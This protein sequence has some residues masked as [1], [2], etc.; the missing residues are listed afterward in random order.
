[1]LTYARHV[2]AGRVHPSRFVS[3]KLIDV[4]PPTP[5]PADILKGLAQAKD[6]RQALDG[7]SPP[8][9][10]YKALRAKLAEARA[11]TSD[12]GPAPIEAGALLR[13]G[14][15]DERVP[16]LRE[17][18]GVTDDPASTAYDAK[19]AEAVKAFQRRSG[20]NPDGVVG[21]ATV[22]A[23][24]GPRKDRDLAAI[25]SNMERWRWLP[26]ELGKL[27][28]IVNIPDFTAQIVRDGKTVHQTRIVVGKPS[29]ATPVFSDSIENI[30]VNPTWHVPE[31]IIYGEY[32]PALQQDPTVLARMGLVMEHNRDGSISIRQ[33]PGEANALGRLKFN[34]PNRHQVYMHD[35]PDKKLFT[36]D[37]R[38][39]SHGCMRVQNPHEFAEVLLGYA[40]P[41]EGLS[42]ERLTRMYGK[43]EQTLKFRNPVSVH[44]TYQTA[45]V[46]GSGKLVVRE[47]LYGHDGKVQM[48]LRSMDRR[49]AD[50]AVPQRLETS[51]VSRREAARQFRPQGSFGLSFFERLF[52][53]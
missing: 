25:I 9:P 4:N 50:I 26:R 44:I 13:I 14:M 22:D 19:L 16:R 23:L 34:F 8:H 41:E 47:D 1:V 52:Q 31:S 21:R 15:Q 7:F 18:L 46:D 20:L 24:N 33:P 48:A 38:S 2:Q 36:H 37:K 30:V 42:A 11:R 40:L 27:H 5:E 49:V 29:T 17:R 32:L 12:T 28:V 6:A 10:G 51:S 53:P 45:F 43:G 3:I 39:Y 35:T